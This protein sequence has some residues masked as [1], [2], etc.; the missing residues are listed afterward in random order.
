MRT[1]RRRQKQKNNSN[2]KLQ[3]TQKNT[4]EKGEGLNDVRALGP[5]ITS[6]LANQAHQQPQEDP[7]HSLLLSGT[8][9]K[10]LVDDKQKTQERFGL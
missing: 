8:F 9:P 7:P 2:Q 1:V 10:P 6:N 4:S 5:N 3:Q